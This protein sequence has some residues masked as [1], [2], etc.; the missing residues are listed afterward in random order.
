MWKQEAQ[1]EKEMEM[2]EKKVEKEMEATDREKWGF[3]RGMSV[4]SNLMQDEAVSWN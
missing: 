1:S 2:E 4:F 3:N